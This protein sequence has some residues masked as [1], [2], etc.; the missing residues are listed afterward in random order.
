[1][2]YYLAKEDKTQL[3]LSVQNDAAGT[4]RHSPNAHLKATATFGKKN[5]I[6]P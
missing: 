4:S 1:M 6:I 2:L 5:G 3:Y